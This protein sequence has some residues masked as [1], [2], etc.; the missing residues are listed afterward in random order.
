MKTLLKIV[1]VLIIIIIGILYYLY[2]QMSYTPD[3]YDKNDSNHI[4]NIISSSDNVDNKIT[5]KLNSGLPVEINSDELS[6]V[7]VS[8]AKN[9]LLINLEKVIKG[10]NT[11]ITTNKITVE[12]VVN[13]KNIPMSQIPPDLRDAFKKFLD[14]IP[15]DVV[16]NFYIKFEGIPK[17]KNGQLQFDEQSF[18]QLGKIKYSIDE[19]SEK[20]IDEQLGNKYKHFNTIPFTS[21]M[22]NEG[23]LKIIP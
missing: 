22:L 13:I 8:N 7:I 15:G 17:S 20:Y 4:K 10:I 16:E 14:T 18:I 11:K 9:Q 19:L 3:W 12:S 5:M 1:A 23:Y 6:A 21:L 2:Y